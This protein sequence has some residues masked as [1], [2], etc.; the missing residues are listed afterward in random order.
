ML[1]PKAKRNLSRIL[2]F[3]L[4]WLASGMV[5]LVVEEAALRDV[6]QHSATRIELDL[7]VFIF[8][9]LAISGVGLLVGAI[10]LLYLDRAFSGKSFGKKILYKLAFY[11]V[12]MFV[13]TLLTFPVAASLELDTSIFDIAVWH[14]LYLYLSSITHLSTNLQLGAALGASL[15]YAEISDNIGHGVL[16]NF[17]TGKYHRPVVEERIFMFLDMRSSTAIAEKLGHTWYFKLLR[18][19]YADLSDAIVQYSGEIYQYVGDEIIVSWK[20][21]A[22]IAD[23]NCIQCFWAMQEA[24]R[25]RAQW[26]YERF[27]VLPAFK[28]GLHVGEVTTGEIGVIKKEITFTGDVLN[29]TARIQG[30]CNSYGVDLLLS[31]ELLESLGGS[32][33][34]QFTSL[35]HHEL[36]GKKVQMELFAV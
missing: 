25:K 6:G 1:S 28:A 30:L 32:A 24:L 13:V 10:E 34:F 20:K 31:G 14:K 22:G 11:T 7:S 18:T 17:F 8:S 19:C 4:I 26:Y 33:L 12:M 2:P 29:A 5:F 35:G 23:N 9:T 36:R 16:I 21:E 3:G 27:G 15:F